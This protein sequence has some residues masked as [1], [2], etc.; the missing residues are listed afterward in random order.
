MANEKQTAASVA[1]TAEERGAPRKRGGMR[2]LVAAVVVVLLEAGTVAVTVKMSAGPRPAIADPPVAAT[3]E[4]VVKDTEVKLVEA[5]LYN[6]QSGKLWLYDMQVVAKVSEK[7]R[8][9]VTE[10]FA[11]HESEIRDRIRT[12]IASS[13]PKSLA[14]PG[15][16]T[17]RRQIAYQ[18]DQDIG[19][20]LVKEVLIPKC[21][22]IRAE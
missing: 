2:M 4:A 11:E 21:T 18:L 14:E 3:A 8:E 7:N 10:L 6:S 1:P 17:I 15:L 13:D 9:K 19:K 22:P 12:I 16:E 5:K 20:E